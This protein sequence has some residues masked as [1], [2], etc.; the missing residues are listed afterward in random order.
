MDNYV[1]VKCDP[2][3]GRMSMSVRKCGSAKVKM[4][5]DASDF[6]VRISPKCSDMEVMKNRWGEVGW[7]DSV[8][9]GHEKS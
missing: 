3:T 6:A 9:I 7:M 8:E 5:I 4:E 1:L 2:K